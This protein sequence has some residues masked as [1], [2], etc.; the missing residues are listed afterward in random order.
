MD[1]NEKWYSVKEF[2]A[3]LSVGVDCVRRWIKAKKLRAFK[4]PKTS[5]GRHRVY[6]C[7]RIAESE[8]Q[9]FIRAQMNF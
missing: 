9:R 5:P 7:H 8:R 6:Y 3:S 2:A 4:M 1:S